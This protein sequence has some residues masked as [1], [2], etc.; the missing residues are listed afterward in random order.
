M[1]I[2]TIDPAQP[3]P[4]DPAGQGD[5][6]LR[7]FKQSIVDT[8]PQAP[9]STPADP[10]DIVLSVGPRALNDVINKATAAD[11]AATDA[12]VGTNTIDIANN[13]AVLLALLASPS[14][15][16]H[17]LI[18]MIA[19]QGMS[20]GG[21]IEANR[22][23][24]IANRANGGILVN[25]NDIG[26]D[27]PGLAA[28]TS[29][30]AGTDEL[31]ISDNGVNK[32]ID[33][34]VLFDQVAGNDGHFR[35]GPILVQ[36]QRISGWVASPT[37]PTFNWITP[38]SGIPYVAVAQIVNTGGGSVTNALQRSILTATQ[39]GFIGS[40]GGNQTRIDVIGIGPA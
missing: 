4:N 9:V 28:L 10:W 7:D 2:D 24:N 30:P 37:N 1:T 31:I 33:F 40:T 23:F 25:A 14:A 12:Q 35:V 11:L 18:S 20:G 6:Q 32:R 17:S 13:T 39:I 26:I 22:T 36:W 34:S 15:L 27:I 8:F 21:T 38:F 3:D 16:D 19:G 5:D 29:V